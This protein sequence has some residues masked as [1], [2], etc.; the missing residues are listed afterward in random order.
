MSRRRGHTLLEAVVS[1]SVVGVLVAAIGSAMLL[2]ARSSPRADDVVARTLESRRV[3]GR[4]AADLSLATSIE[5]RSEHVIVLTLA[6]QDADGAGEH[7]A[8]VW[9][10]TPG[11]PIRRVQ[12]GVVTHVVDDIRAF[13]IDWT[14]ASR[15]VVAPTAATH[16]LEVLLAA[17]D[18]SHD[19]TTRLSASTHAAQY[20]LPSLPADATHY[21]ITRA[22]V[23]VTKND[24]ISGTMM[25]RICRTNSSGS[26]LMPADATS[27]ALLSLNLLPASW[28][29]FNFASGVSNI[30]AG[31]GRWIVI[32]QSLLPFV[33][34]LVQRAVAHTTSHMG[35]STDA[36]TSWTLRHDSSLRYELYGTIRRPGSMVVSTQHA[37]GATVH[38]AIG[39]TSARAGA[40]AVLN[41]RP[42][43][44]S[45]SA[46]PVEVD[47]SEGEIDLDAVVKMI[48]SGDLGAMSDTD[49]LT[50]PA[51]SP[52]GGG[53]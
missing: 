27:S 44:P 24:L 8:W 23:R 30:P 39:N 49:P 51:E 20:V 53:K 42:M 46:E 41:A 12:N 40:S 25:A 11:D 37:L 15:N 13:S 31:E 43:L 38:V 16:G 3:A 47:I 22:R 50:D 14:T 33:D 17:F 32:Y 10:G 48:E 36:G 5:N 6:D 9:S 18:D 21:T 45:L 29:N 34:L 35:V 19:S 2:A 4:I 26:P 7:I 1:L 28:I 52:K